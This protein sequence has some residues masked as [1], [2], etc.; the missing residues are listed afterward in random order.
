MAIIK[1][2]DHST[3][4]LSQYDSTVTDGGDLSVTEAAALAG[5]TYGMQFGIDDTTAME[6]Q[7]DFSI[8]AS[9]TAIRVRYYFDI[10][11]LYMEDANEFYT[12]YCSGPGILWLIKIRKNVANYEL[13]WRV[14]DDSNGS[15]E[16]GY[17]TFTDEPHYV[18]LL[19]E[20]AAT[21]VSSDASVQMWIDGNSEF[22]A[23]GFDIY[24]RLLAVSRIEMA[25]KYVSAAVA[26]TIYVD[27]LVVRNDDTEIGP[28]PAGGD[29]LSTTM[30]L[31]LGWGI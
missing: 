28:V 26:G 29:P 7:A 3:G 1:D 22:S 4:D 15:H 10:N 9:D 25:V 24:D 16:S 21:D 17:V 27:Q 18:E 12:Q 11:S 6:A 5:T 13:L 31:A 23:S 30:R 8:D 20:R 2:I 14:Y 19:V